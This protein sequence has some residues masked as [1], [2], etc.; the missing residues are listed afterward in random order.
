MRLMT[1]VDPQFH[2]GRN[3]TIRRGK[4]WSRL[5]KGERIAL[6]RSLSNSKKRIIVRVEEV[7]VC[8]YRELERKDVEESHISQCQGGKEELLEEMKRIHKGKKRAFSANET[9]TVVYFTVRY[10][11]YIDSYGKLMHY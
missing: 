5:K 10:R 11:T 9:V 2:E 6:V 4:F 7:K 1:F 8:R 3:C